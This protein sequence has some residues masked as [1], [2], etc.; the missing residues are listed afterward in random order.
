MSKTGTPSTPPLR[1]IGDIVRV[2]AEANPNRVACTFEGRVTTYAMLHAYTNKV[3]HA[4]LAS[5]V[6]ADGRVGYLGKNSDRYLEILFGAAKMGAVCLPIG[7]RLA[8]AEV[9]HIVEDGEASILFVG[10]EFGDLAREAIKL[11]DRPIRIV[12]LESESSDGFTAW[13]GGHDTD[14]PAIDVDPSSTALQLYTS[15]TTGRPKGVMLSHDNLLLTWTKVGDADLSWYRWTDDDVSLMAM[16]V[17]HI[18]GT[19]WGLISLREG[20]S[21]VILKEFDPQAVLQ[22][23]EPERITKMFMVP[24]ALNFLIQMPGANDIDFGH[25]KLILYGASPMPLALLRQCMD[26]FGCDFC[27]QYGM[28]ETCGTI[29]YLPPEDHDPEGNR[30]MRSAGLPM[31]GV[32]LK[33]M[34][35]DGKALPPEEVGEV[36]TRSPS[37]MLGYWKKEAATRETIDGDG[38]LRSGDAGYLDADGYLYIHDRVKDMIISGAEN[39]YPAEVESAMFGHPDI[40]D[41][42]I[43]G[44][45]DDKWGEAVKAV[46]VLKPGTEANEA[47]ILTFTRERIASFKVPKSI[48]FVDE[49]PR[50]A[51][52]KVLKRTLREPYWAGRDR[53]VN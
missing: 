22:V 40:A 4:L 20:A 46:I 39:I 34:D 8:A 49:L 33:I 50:N 28:T 36:A 30:R 31:P 42:A 47:D 29:V 3:A 19:G 12:E 35:A 15:G 32:E 48:D 18:G 14:D 21:V 2:H 52:G 11:I 26:V 13:R 43:I 45:P 41:V 5:G 10:P 24:A 23:M 9:A 38:W 7:W 44:V 37:N 6:K 17:A 1:T 16:P 51:T 27:Q 25:L 53:A